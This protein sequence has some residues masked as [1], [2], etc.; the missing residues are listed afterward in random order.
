MTLGNGNDAYMLAQNC[1]HVYGFDIA[2]EAIENSTERL[3]KF[4]NVTLINDSHVNVDKYINDRV[5]MFVFNL[6]YLPHSDTISTTKANDTLQAFKKAYDLLQDNGYIII[7]FYLGHQGGKDE[8]YL[9]DSYIHKNRIPILESYRQD[10]IDS[11][12]TYII[13]KD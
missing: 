10:K 12:I 4:N 1:K 11:P 6:G 8:Y 7:T 5:F 3:K 13:R 2:L 9:L